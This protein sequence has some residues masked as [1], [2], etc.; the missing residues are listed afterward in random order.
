MEI[1]IATQDD[2]AEVLVIYEYARSFMAENGNPTQWKKSYPPI[3]TVKEDIANKKLYLCIANGRIACVFYYSEGNDPTYDV[4]DG[5]WQNNKTYGV[6]HRIASAEGTRGAATFCLTW[7]YEKCKNLKIDTHENNIPMQNL[8]KK[9]GFSHC[10]I[11]TLA[12]GE[13]RWAYQKS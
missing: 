7:A 8:L 12:S 3:E 10:G 2:L 9:L 6:V 5:A 13:F 1:R 11:I 4:I